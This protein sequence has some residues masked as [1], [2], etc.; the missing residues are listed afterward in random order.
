MLPILAVLAACG[1]AQAPAEPSGSAE[2]AV[3]DWVLA[4]GTIDGVDA[5]A[6]EDHRITL[7]LKGRTIDGVAA[8][9]E[10]GGEIATGGD[11]LHI[12]NLAQT[13]MACEEPAMAVES[14]YLGALARVREIERDGEQL[15]A[16]GDGVDL[17]FDPLAP[18]PT[19]MLVDRLWVLDTVL[20]GDVASAPI[21]ER[22]TLRLRGDGTFEG[23]TGCRSFSGEWLE[24]GDQIVTPRWGM[25]V[26]A[27]PADRTAQDNHVVSVIGDGF[28]P[29]VD[30]DLLT[31]VDPGGVAL[32]YRSGG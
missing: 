21:G 10:Y 1:A 5:P 28:I 11:G 18:P 3:G 32:V 9:N 15:T 30:G 19:P 23:S 4:G 25:D 22:A 26:T 24:R 2:P 8:C 17:R 20:V 14:R 12:E 7:T 16:R 13:E 31:L 27:C 6:S 29:S